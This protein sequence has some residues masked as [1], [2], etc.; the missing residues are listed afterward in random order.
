MTTTKKNKVIHS[1]HGT[2]FH[3]SQNFLNKK[4]RNKRKIKHM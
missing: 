1:A 2:I 3:L 4:K